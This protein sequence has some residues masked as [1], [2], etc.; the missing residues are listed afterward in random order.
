LTARRPAALRGDDD[1]AAIVDDAFEM[2]ELAARHVRV[3]PLRGFDA[4]AAL[5]ALFA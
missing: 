2:G 4:A 1:A 3:S 5:R